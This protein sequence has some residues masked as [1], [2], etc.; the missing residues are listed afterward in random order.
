MDPIQAQYFTSQLELIKKDPN[1]TQKKS[2]IINLID[3][4][5]SG[6]EFSTVNDLGTFTWKLLKKSKALTPEHFIEI[7]TKVVQDVSESSEDY[8][9]TGW[10]IKNNC[11]HIRADELYRSDFWNRLRKNIE[12]MDKIVIQGIDHE[13]P[14][15]IVQEL[16]KRQPDPL[17]FQ[18]N[19]Q[20]IFESEPQRELFPEYLIRALFPNLFPSVEI[21]F[22]TNGN[23]ERSLNLKVDWQAFTQIKKYIET[24]P[25]PDLFQIQG[26][27][28]A[29]LIELLCY[30]GH[31]E[32]L[33]KYL[34]ITRLGSPVKQ[35][36]QLCSTEKLEWFGNLYVNLKQPQIR[37]QI[38]NYFS[39]ILFHVVYSWK[40]SQRPIRKRSFISKQGLQTGE[41][42]LSPRNNR[43]IQENLPPIPKF[44]PELIQIL[45]EIRIPHLII[46]YEAPDW[47][48][49][50]IKTLDSLTSI[51]LYQTQLTNP[52]C[53]HAL[54]EMQMR[55]NFKIVYIPLS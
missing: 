11:L 41:T 33:E 35:E 3:Q 18:K 1:N 39:H 14:I 21:A 46:K 8:R 5:W 55:G 45:D 32:H 13:I 51:S 4:M 50:Q 53:K 20:C 17:C 28:A 2:R 37:E 7:T 44:F 47:F 22:Q 15:G 6:I 48:W 16:M 43:P 29:E 12:K 52:H 34:G 30:A 25:R 19:V 9:S 31:A 26:G 54:D 24:V 27:D 10:M 40:R 49:Q 38:E 23:P 42:Q 36:K